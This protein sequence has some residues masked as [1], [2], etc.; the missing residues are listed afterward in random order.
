M[1][2]PPRCLKIVILGDTMRDTK[3]TSWKRSFN[4][5]TMVSSF[6]HCAFGESGER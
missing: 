1:N 2:S 6:R 4:G 5:I 3:N